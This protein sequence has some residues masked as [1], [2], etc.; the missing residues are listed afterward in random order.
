MQTKVGMLRNSS[1]VYQ[2]TMQNSLS[3]I[4]RSQ[5]EMYGNRRTKLILLMMAAVWQ[6]ILKWA[7]TSTSSDVGFEL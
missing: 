4:W 6:W 5:F 3:T 1:S 7:D 2:Q